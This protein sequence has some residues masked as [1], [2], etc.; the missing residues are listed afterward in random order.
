MSNGSNPAGDEML[1][2]R[3]AG[4][5]VL[6]SVAL[7]VALGAALMTVALPGSSMAARLTIGAF[8][9]FWSSPFFGTALATGYH[10][11]RRHAAAP[12]VA[13]PRH[14]ADAAPRAAAA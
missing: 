4:I 1:L 11:H 3:R 5:A 6:L 7:F 14:T 13:L 10:L 8:L 12:V 2:W 9:G